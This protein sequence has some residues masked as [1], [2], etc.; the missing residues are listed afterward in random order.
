MTTKTKFTVLFNT[1]NAAFADG[2]TAEIARILRE[3]ADKVEENGL[4]EDMPGRIK[5]VNGARVGFYA[6]ETYDTDYQER[7]READPEKVRV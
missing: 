6:L 2:K 1:D 5:D 4:I 7:R 3:I